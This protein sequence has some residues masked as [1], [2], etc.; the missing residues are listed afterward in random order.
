MTMN[1][2][3][4]KYRIRFVTAFIDLCNHLIVT[5]FQILKRSFI[6]V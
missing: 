5:L 3:K 6:N 4:F 2:Q 1:K